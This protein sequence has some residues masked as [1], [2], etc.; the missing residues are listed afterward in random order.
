MIYDVVQ[1]VRDR[2]YTAKSTFGELAYSAQ[3]T[4]II[5]NWG[6][7]GL[8]KVSNAFFDAWMDLGQLRDT[9]ANWEQYID[10]LPSWVWS[11]WWP[12]FKAELT[13]ATALGEVVWNLVYDQIKARW[14]WLNTIDD[15]IRDVV[16]AELGFIGSID[17]RIKDVAW[18]HILPKLGDWLMDWLIINVTFM[19]KMGYRVL[20]AIWNMEWDDD[21]KE[22]KG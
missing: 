21:N 20:D 16:R 3:D 7:V 15:K 18:N 19:A 13:M 8:M 6:Y 2:V 5:G 10:N 14:T 22:V 12:R 1:F 11:W 17:D 4:P 9:L